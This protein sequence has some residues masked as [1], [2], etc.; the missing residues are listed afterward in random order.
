MSMG[1]TIGSLSKPAAKGLL[2]MAAKW[3]KVSEETMMLFTQDFKKG[4]WIEWWDTSATATEFRYTQRDKN[5]WSEK[6]WVEEA[7]TIE[8]HQHPDGLLPSWTD[9]T[10]WTKEFK[11][12]GK[13]VFM[14]YQWH[15]YTDAAIIACFDHHGNVLSQSIDGKVCHVSMIDADQNTSAMCLVQNRN[16]LQDSKHLV[17]K[18]LR[19]DLFGDDWSARDN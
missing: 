18:A 4:Q 5:I 10:T 11:K 7:K 19:E 17:Q 2:K 12:S 6:M 14:I 8:A 16:E 9:I 15:P 1:E 13:N 3:K